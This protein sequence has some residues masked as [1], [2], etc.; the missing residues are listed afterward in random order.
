MFKD[1]HFKGSLHD[2][3]LRQLQQTFSALGSRKLVGIV[4]TLVI[5]I[6]LPFTL[7]QVG[8][9][10]ELRQK[11]ADN[12]RMEVE[13]GINKTGLITVA[14]DPQASGGQYVLFGS[15]PTPPLTRPIFGSWF[16]SP[17]LQTMPQAK[18]LIL[19]YAKVVYP[20]GLNWCGP[21]DWSDPQA[22][23]NTPPGFY[24]VNTTSSNLVIRDSEI[25][26]RGIIARGYVWNSREGDHPRPSSLPADV[27][28]PLFE[29]A[30]KKVEIDCVKSVMNTYKDRASNWRMVNEIFE[31]NGQRRLAWH[32]NRAVDISHK[33]V[34]AREVD[35]NAKLYIEDYGA[36]EINPKSTGMLNY[37]KQLRQLGYPIHG[38]GFQG[39][40]SLKYPPNIQSI[41]DNVQRFKNEGFEVAF[42]EV[43]VAIDGVTGTDAE[44]RQRQAD[45]FKQT[46][47][48]CKD[49]SN[50]TYYMLFGMD[51]NN[52]WLGPEAKA[53]PF[54]IN[55]QPK[56]AFQAL[57]AVLGL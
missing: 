32:T 39:H 25:L 43:D 41:R 13:A 27:S 46:A 8:K 7:I 17:K 56:P 24:G 10:Q 12:P 26:Q 11:A 4:L 16:E 35:P 38:I 33:L 1:Y 29:Q 22:I 18:S 36:E 47:Q 53:R 52:D 50:C 2:N 45:I 5:A 55:F 34:A 49:F 14:S 3:K 37:M 51:D 57:Q 42:T 6:A 21:A 31:T 19:Q 30:M 44:K 40:F 9:R 54:D 28:N 23:I 20:E 48:I 15:G